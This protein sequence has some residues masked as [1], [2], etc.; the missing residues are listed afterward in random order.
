M[1]ASLEAVVQVF[2]VKGNEVGG[3]QAAQP[4][5]PGCA[6]VQHLPTQRNQAV[7][8]GGQGRRRRG[9]Q[10]LLGGQGQQVQLLTSLTRGCLTADQL[11]DMVEAGR[12][13]ADRLAAFMQQTARQL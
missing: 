6:A 1:G 4:G 10:L 3:G 12:H 11:M 9:V 8:R 7:E 13:G 5:N 2:D